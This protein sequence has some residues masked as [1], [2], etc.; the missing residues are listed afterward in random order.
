MINNLQALKLDE[1]QV[2]KKRY[3]LRRTGRRG[4]TIQVSIPPEVF[5]REAR[6][7][8]LNIEEAVRTLQAVWR[9]DS[10][11]GLYLSFEPKEGASIE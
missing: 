7:Q 10:F 1:K 8:D 2:L 6:R 5:E 11:K 9:F 4:S 3:K